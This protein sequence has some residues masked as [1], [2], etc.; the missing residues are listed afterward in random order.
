MNKATLQ[1]YVRSTVNSTPRSA[2]TITALIQK[3][4]P[5]DKQIT[6]G[7]VKIILTQL[8]YAGLVKYIEPD[9]YY[10]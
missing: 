3:H 8:H 10:V 5:N 4:F 6:T 1:T 2:Q 7:K 9:L